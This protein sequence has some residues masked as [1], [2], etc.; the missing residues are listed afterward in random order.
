MEAGL[1]KLSGNCSLLSSQK[2]IVAARISFKAFYMSD[3]ELGD[4]TTSTSGCSERT[5]YIIL[6]TH[7]IYNTRN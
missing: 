3:I 6:Q 5:H 2:G 4:T 7:D 1:F